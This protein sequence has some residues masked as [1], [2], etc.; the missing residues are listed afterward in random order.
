MHL[1][2]TTGKPDYFETFICSAS[3]ADGTQVN[4][5][6]RTTESFTIN[7]YQAWRGGGV[8]APPHPASLFH[9]GAKRSE[10]ARREKHFTVSS[11]YSN[12]GHV[13]STEIACDPCRNPQFAE[14]PEAVE[15]HHHF[16]RGHGVRAGAHVPWVL[17]SHYAVTPLLPRKGFR[18]SIQPS[19]FPTQ[20]QLIAG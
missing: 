12:Y 3:P 10:R 9:R 18:S 1:F 16:W 8:S 14:V 15:T 19:V 2:S 13:D 4:R 20:L 7:L 11:A 17:S 6:E 5:N